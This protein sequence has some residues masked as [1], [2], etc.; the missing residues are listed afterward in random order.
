M[1]NF[2]IK[3]RN[4]LEILGNGNRIMNYSTWNIQGL[5]I[6]QMKKQKL[7]TIPTKTKKN[8]SL[9]FRGTVCRIVRLIRDFPARHGCHQ[10]G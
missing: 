7:L 8:T 4:R 1:E 2:S 9:V 5:Q 3:R 10:T 6:R